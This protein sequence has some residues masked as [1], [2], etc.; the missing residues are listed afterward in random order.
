[1]FGSLS[2][3]PSHESVQKLGTTDEELAVLLHA[4]QLGR[5]DIVQQAISSLKT[6]LD[7][8]IEVVKLIS[9]SRVYQIDE[10]TSGTGTPLHVASKHG[11]SDVVRAL[12]NAQAD[13]TVVPEEG[14]FADKTAYAVANSDKILQTFHVYLFEQIAM[15]NNI[16]VPII[17]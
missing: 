10:N 8:D 7:N 6:I 5:T 15:G 12:L 2:R 4:S 16:K 14:E 11:H 3:E 1:M 9:A 13:P 17:I